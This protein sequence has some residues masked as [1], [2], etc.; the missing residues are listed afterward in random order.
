MI[1]TLSKADCMIADA[2]KPSMMSREKTLLNTNL[3]L[4]AIY[5][6]P[7]HH[8]TLSNEQIDRGKVALCDLAVQ[9][10][11]I[12]KQAPLSPTTAAKSDVATDTTGSSTGIP[13]SVNEIDFEKHLDNKAK[14][15]RIALEN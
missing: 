13:D 8:L 1:F 9:M 15:R 12:Q 11:L 2:I 5:V 14:C 3:L 10:H 7:M 4:A 6:D